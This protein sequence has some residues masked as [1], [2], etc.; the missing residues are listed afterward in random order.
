MHLF[1]HSSTHTPTCA[2]AGGVSLYSVSHVYSLISTF[3]NL[4]THSF[5]YLFIKSLDLWATVSPRGALFNSY[6]W[7]LFFYQLSFLP[8]LSFPLA[9][10]SGISSCTWQALCTVV[11]RAAVAHTVLC[12]LLQLQL[13]SSIK[14]AAAA[15]AAEASVSH[16][17]IAVA[18]ISL[19]SDK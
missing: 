9:N 11:Q 13:Y 10:I 15:A 7:T 18:I 14:A 12:V 4:L 19:S 6:H 2:L 3:I 17:L 8:K 5:I 16:P 1:N